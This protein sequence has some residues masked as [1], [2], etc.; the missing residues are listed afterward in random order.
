MKIQRQST[1]YQDI[2]SG[3]MIHNEKIN[4]AK[5]HDRGE[6]K[7]ATHLIITP[8]KHLTRHCITLNQNGDSPSP[9]KSYFDKW[10]K[11][12][13]SRALR[14]AF[15]IRLAPHDR[16]LKGSQGLDVKGY[17]HFLALYYGDGL[18]RLISFI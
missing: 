16:L 17:F 14:T 3:I 18:G 7:S 15:C 8:T 5:P 12:I 10:I 4:E 13:K 1:H 9:Y 2:Q 6:N 11:T